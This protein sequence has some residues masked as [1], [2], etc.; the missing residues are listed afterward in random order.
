MLEGLSHFVTS[1]LDGS[2]VRKEQ[3]HEHF[4]DTNP[5]ELKEL[6]RKSRT[7]RRSYQTFR[8][9]S[10][11]SQRD[12]SSSALIA[13]NFPAGSLLRIRNTNNLFACREFEGAPR[14]TGGQHPT[15][16]VLDG[17]QRL[18]SLSTRRSTGRA[19]IVTS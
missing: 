12:A 7:A 13:S 11:G 3:G 15:Y 8:G 9:I 17:Q 18:T 14:Q 5:R 16:L 19:T 2:K 6:L 1:G 4:R 10:F